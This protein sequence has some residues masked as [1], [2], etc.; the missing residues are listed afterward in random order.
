MRKEH[1]V[2]ILL[3]SLLCLLIPVTGCYINCG[4][5][6]LVKHERTVTLSAP[7][8]KGSLFNAKTHNGY[9][10][11]IGSDV[12]DCNMTATIIAKAI[13][14]EDAQKL[15]EEVKVTLEPLGNELIA[16]IEKPQCHRNCS[17]R[18]NIN[19]TVPNRTNLQLITHN[20]SLK[21]SNITGQITGTTHNGKVIVEKIS[22]TTFLQTHNGGI[23]A[24]DIAGDV[25]LRTHNGK[26][27]AYFSQSAP[28]DSDISMKTHN[29]GIYL[30]APENFSAKVDVSTHNGSIHTD[31][32]ITILGKVTKRRLTG[33]IGTGQGK[34]HLKTHNG[35]IKIE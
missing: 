16:K 24:K 15:A 12:A 3:V 10:T 18:V 35:S 13:S 34:L 17:V 32:P 20:G 8:A 19:A 14:E 31:L 25:K 33:T 4:R 2:I 5:C 21:L 22:G 7:L 28:P 26:V 9:I 29:G 1:L 11:I 27:K 23:Y 6:F 30:D